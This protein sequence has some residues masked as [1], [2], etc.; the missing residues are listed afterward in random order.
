MGIGHATDDT[1]E[2]QKRLEG[3]RKQ[4]L[5]V[6]IFEVQ[7]NAE[8]RQMFAWFARNRPI[9][10]AVREFFDQSD[11]F[12]KVAKEAMD[13]SQTLQEHVTWKVR[14]LPQRGD[15]AVRLL[16]LNNLKEIVTTIRIGIRR[17]P[18][19]ADREQCWEPDTQHELLE[20]LV[21]FFDEFLPSCQPNYS[22]LDNPKELTR[23]IRGDRNVSYACYPSVMRLMANAWARWRF[24]RGIEP[25]PLAAAVG[26]INL[27]IA[28]PENFIREQELITG[29]SLRFQGLRHEHWEKATSEILRRTGKD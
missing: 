8:H 18:K 17:G 6:V 23:N 29:R 5:P 25:A 7:S 19:A 26:T 2:T 10:P 9:E 15:E 21:E 16:T 12:G 1:G 20:R 27:R 4:D 11:P 24:D 13:R 28:D 22:V 3:L 14:T